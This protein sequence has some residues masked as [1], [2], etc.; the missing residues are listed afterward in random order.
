MNKCQ[1][2][3][4][5]IIVNIFICFQPRYADREFLRPSRHCAP[6]NHLLK[7]IAVVTILLQRFRK[8]YTGT[9]IFL[10]KIKIIIFFP[11]LSIQ[12]LIL[13]LSIIKSR[14]FM[15]CD[16]QRSSFRRQKRAF[17]CPKIKISIGNVNKIPIFSFP[18]SNDVDKISNFPLV[19]GGSVVI[20]GRMT[21]K[22]HIVEIFLIVIF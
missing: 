12:N 2:Y 4:C 1:K 7:Q 14:Y 10:K 11:I 17:Q 5:E 20:F 9:N 18:F 21:R 19:L 8:D 15:Q 3:I 13:D 16:F 22:R 6:F